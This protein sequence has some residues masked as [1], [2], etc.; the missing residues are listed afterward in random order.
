MKRRKKRGQK[1][2]PQHRSP[3]PKIAPIKKKK[4][5]PTKKVL[6]GAGILVGIALIVLASVFWIAPALKKDTVD[7]SRY[8]RLSLGGKNGE[9]VVIYDCDDS[10]L[11]EALGRTSENADDFYSEDILRRLDYLSAFQIEIS[12]ATGLSNNDVVSVKVSF[13][14]N[15][16]SKAKVKAVNDEY[17][18]VVSG[19][20]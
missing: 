8:V 13:P 7:M 3:V 6:I 12:P 17:T 5:F 10:Y 19:L 20:E 9:G 18:F 15:Y 1:R 2:K 16:L 11:A 4:P 14:G